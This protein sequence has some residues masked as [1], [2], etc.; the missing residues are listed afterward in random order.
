MK[1]SLWKLLVII[2]AG[3]VAVSCVAPATADQSSAKAV[4]TSLYARLQ[5]GRYD[6]A[7]TLLR[8]TDGSVLAAATQATVRQSWESA[9]KGRT[10]RVTSITLTAERPL[11]DDARALLP[12]GADA[13][14]LTLEVDGESDAP[15][16]TLPLKNGT[17][18]AARIDDRWYL[19]EELHFAGSYVVR[20]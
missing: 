13:V 1:P 14:R 10:F 17:V 12:T 20:C 4:V 18:S 5:A 7:V 11:E 16:W 15:C 19:I 2:L 6:D 9:L 3:A 8:A